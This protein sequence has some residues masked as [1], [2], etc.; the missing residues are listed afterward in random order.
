MAGRLKR[1]W[2][3]MVCQ[4]CNKRWEIDGTNPKAKV[5]AQSACATCGQR[6]KRVA[7]DYY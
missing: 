3:Q 2:L 1:P 6:G 5:E 7:T 4:K